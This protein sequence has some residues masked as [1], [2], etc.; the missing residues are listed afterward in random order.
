MSCEGCLTSGKGQN[1]ALEA[2]VKSAKD[3]AIQHQQTMAIYKEGLGYSFIEAATA[4]TN[5]YPIIQFVSQHS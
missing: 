1:Q 3:Y 5:G 4:I 2:A